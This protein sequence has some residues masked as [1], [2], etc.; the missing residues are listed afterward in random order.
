MNLISLYGA[1]DGQ[2]HGLL[3]QFHVGGGVV[4]AGK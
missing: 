3:F 1:L 4:S 2:Y